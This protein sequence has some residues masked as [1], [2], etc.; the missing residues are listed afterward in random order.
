MPYTLSR[1][2]LYLSQFGANG[3]AK[4]LHAHEI[5]GHQTGI[6]YA[7][8]SAYASMV[9]RLFKRIGNEAYS[10]GFFTHWFS[11]FVKEKERV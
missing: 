6:M 1:I 4:Q 10:Y 3:G 7:C 5:V 8:L 2:F 11:R 9:L